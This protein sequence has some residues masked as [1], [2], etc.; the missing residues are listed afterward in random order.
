VAARARQELRATRA[1][2]EDMQADIRLLLEGEGVAEG[3][4]VDA[5]EVR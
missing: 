2:V 4:I 1:A 5:Q 3:A